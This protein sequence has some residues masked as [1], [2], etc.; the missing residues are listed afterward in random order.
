MSKRGNVELGLFIVF[1]A[2]AVL[3]LIYTMLDGGSTG[4]ALSPTDIRSPMGAVSPTDIRGAIS[5]TDIVRPNNVCAQLNVLKQQPQTP[6]VQGRMQSL[7]QQ[8]AAEQRMQTQSST[9]SAEQRKR[10]QNIMGQIR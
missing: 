6:A 9:S 4:L 10:L 8:C 2:V 5:P 7:T 3:G 1:S